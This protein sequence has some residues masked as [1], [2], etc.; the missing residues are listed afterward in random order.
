MLSY[1]DLIE[2]IVP[3]NIYMVYLDSEQKNKWTFWK[4]NKESNRLKHQEKLT[5]AIPRAR[6][7]K[8]ESEP[9]EKRREERTTQVRISKN[10]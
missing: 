1:F 4:Q 6:I 10:I 3:G 9:R 7:D 5:Y 2:V 8:R